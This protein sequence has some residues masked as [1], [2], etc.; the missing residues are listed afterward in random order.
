MARAGILGFEG[1]GQV[2]TGNFDRGARRTNSAILL[3]EHLDPFEV[4]IQRFDGPLWE[5]G[6]AVPA[7]FTRPNR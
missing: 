4:D 5:E 3:P 2:N 7:T 6:P 1:G